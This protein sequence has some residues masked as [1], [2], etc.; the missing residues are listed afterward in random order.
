[1]NEDNGWYKND[2]LYWSSFLTGKKKT[3]VKRV[4]W[5]VERSRL[6]QNAHCPYLDHLRT[7]IGLLT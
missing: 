6:N 2:Y 7:P 5:L 4:F 1:M 3:R